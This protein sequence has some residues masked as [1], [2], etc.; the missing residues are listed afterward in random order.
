M[1]EGW[2]QG[3]A[4]QMLRRR[5]AEGEG[6]GKVG[7]FEHL[8]LSIVKLNS[9]RHIFGTSRKSGIEEKPRRRGRHCAAA[10]SGK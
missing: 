2:E 7:S 6:E 9:I 4:A 3:L 5:G 8:Q 1:Q 10:I